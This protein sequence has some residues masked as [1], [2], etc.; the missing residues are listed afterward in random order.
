[1]TKINFLFLFIVLVTNG[2]TYSQPPKGP[3]DIS[4]E[5]I[6]YDE[7]DI[8]APGRGAEQWHNGSEA[9]NYPGAGAVQR[10]MDVYYRFTWNV[11]EDSTAGDYNWTYFDG[12]IKEA[13]DNGQKFS[14][15]IMP[16]Y[17]DDANG[18]IKYDGG[19]SA[20]PLYLHRLMQ[21]APAPEQDWLNGDGVWI[22]NWNSPHYLKRLRAL[23]EALYA[24]IIGT[25]Y[26]PVK[27]PLAGR[28]IAY[29]DAIFCIDV[30]GYGNYG[31]WHSAGIVRRMNDYPNGRR[32]SLATL[33]TIIDHHTQVFDQWPL[34]IMIAAFDAEQVGI[35]MN[36][37][38]LA[39]YALT[40][41]NA[42][43]PLGWRRDQWG[44]TDGYLNNILKHNHKSIKNS[45]PFRKL[46]MSR[47]QTAPI[48]GEP[49]RYV[50]KDGRCAYWDLENQVKE[51]GASS[52]GNGNWGIDMDECASNNARDA[53]KRTGYRL[54]LT[55]GKIPPDIAPGVSFELQLDWKNIGVAPTYEE[56]D[57]WFELKDSAEQVVW[58]A[59]SAFRPKLF[60]PGTKSTE[61]IDKYILPDSIRPGHY[62]L[63]VVIRDPKNYRSP[64]PLAIAGR[65]AGGSYLLRS[66]NIGE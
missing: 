32:A 35:I 45:E 6:P 60:L 36:P 54:I 22:P 8:I 61:S 37:S 38:E 39:H 19:V 12:L 17:G 49:P 55:G 31:E 1:M 3:N 42:W 58:T 52:I 14:F 4:F 20:Y 26:T 30:R 10:S 63:E 18:V 34:V 50:N 27:G 11:L 66:V 56:W 23:H 33:K 47:Y 44:A 53:F 21:A 46:I 2:C 65:K 29:K 28:S 57:V 48:T 24:H 62:S 25:S 51:Y 7:P 41:R 64:L 13:I 43:G 5:M 9:V 16:C 40:T 15:G 59:R